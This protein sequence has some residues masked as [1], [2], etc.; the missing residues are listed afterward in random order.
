MENILNFVPFYV[1]KC[2][3]MILKCSASNNFRL[4]DFRHKRIILKM[5]SNKVKDY[6]DLLPFLAKYLS[7]YF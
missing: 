3:I 5:F 6:I 2:S 7:W 1:S 4:L